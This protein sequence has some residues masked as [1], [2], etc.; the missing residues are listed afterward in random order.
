MLE[1]IQQILMTLRACVHVYVRVCVGTFVWWGAYVGT[2]SQP[3]TI[4]CIKYKLLDSDEATSTAY[5]INMF[6]LSGRVFPSL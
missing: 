4:I 3:F 2:N 1:Q 5:D 6:W